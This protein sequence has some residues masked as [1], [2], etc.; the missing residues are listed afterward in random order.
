MSDYYNVNSLKVEA[1]FQSQMRNMMVVSSLAF[2]LYNVKNSFMK[3]YSY[4]LLVLSAVLLSI[5]MVIAYK[6][7]TEYQKKIRSIDMS[8]KLRR[9]TSEWMFFPICYGIFWVILSC[10]YANSN[11]GQ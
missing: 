4:T 9:D 10:C 11:T 6:S 8:K 1:V 2:V 5:S 3:Q 7:A